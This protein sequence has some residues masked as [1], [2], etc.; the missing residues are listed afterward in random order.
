MDEN[1]IKEKMMIAFRIRSEIVK[2]FN[3]HNVRVSISSS[4]N[5]CYNQISEND[6]GFICQYYYG[7]PSKIYTPLGY[8]RIFDNLYN[9]DGIDDAIKEFEESFGLVLKHEAHYDKNLGEFGGWYYITKLPW[10]D[11]I[12]FDTNYDT[13]NMKDFI[14]YDTASMISKEAFDEYKNIKFTE[15]HNALEKEYNLS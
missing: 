15:D 10:D 12:K 8:L 9:D 7:N 5:Q 1:K 6:N 4:I 3:R 13:K 11:K 14:D 2:I